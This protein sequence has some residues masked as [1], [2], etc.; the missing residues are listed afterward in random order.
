MK[1]ISGRSPWPS[2]RSDARI[3]EALACDLAADVL[4]IGAGLV[5]ALVSDALSSAGIEAIVV[6]HHDLAAGSTQAST[7]LLQYDLDVPLFKLVELIPRDDAVR[8]YRLGVEAIDD[9][10]ES[11]RELDVG[12]ERRRS[13]YV[14][15]SSDAKAELQ[16]EFNAR[17]E[18]G[19]N[20]RLADAADLRSGWGME[21]EAAIVSETAAQVDPVRL[22]DALLARS[23]RR[24]IRVF[25]HVE[26]VAMEN[27]DSLIAR[28][29]S[30]AK[31]RCRFVVHAEGYEAAKL[32]PGGSV[33]SYATFAL[34]S[35]SFMPPTPIWGDRCL[36]WEYA[37]PYL[38]ARWSGDR[39]MVGGEDVKQEMKRDCRPLLAKKC[40]ELKA[41]LERWFPGIR[42]EVETSWCGPF[43]TT[44]DGVGFVGPIDEGSNVLLALCYGGNGMTHA[45]VAGRLIADYVHGRKNKD[46]EIFRVRRFS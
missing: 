9:L 45:V 32:L 39:V 31:I 16:R 15:S 44:R 13:L 20:A 33:E 19:L 11:T 10:E 28:T 42:L 25:D 40:G 22:T 18:A 6:D 41:K 2:A 29:R 36:L 34:L 30:G 23:K 46:A 21:A 27:S 7:A 35:K 5:G 14:A 4:V 43:L 8:A 17:R 38:Y 24:G 37:T 1:P 3:A 26:I 12:F